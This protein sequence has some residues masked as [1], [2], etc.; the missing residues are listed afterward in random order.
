MARPIKLT[1][2]L[3]EQAVKEFAEALGGVKMLEG[4]LN[5]NK[6]FV[7]KDEQKA[8]I[9]FTPMA[10]L[11][12]VTLINSFDIEVAWHGVG[13]RYEETGVEGDFLIEDIVVYPQTVTSTTVEMDEGEYAQWIMDNIE[14]ERFNHIIMQGHSH[15]NMGTSPSGV[16]LQHQESILAQLTDDMF[17]IFLIWNKKLETNTRI[18]DLENNIYYDDKD[19]SYHLVDDGD[20]LNQFITDAKEIVKKKATTWNSNTSGKSSTGYSSGYS[21]GAPASKSATS[22]AQQPKSKQAAQPKSY[23]SYGYG[24]SHY[25]WDDDYWERRWN[26]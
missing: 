15:V 13:R 24:S 18:Y 17:Y 5:Y 20:N 25:D 21:Y 23:G 14:D 26:R 4:K 22:E 1:E 12:M 9:F 7:F 3:R 19:I 8:R 6:S 16:D 11:K 10:Y 2:A